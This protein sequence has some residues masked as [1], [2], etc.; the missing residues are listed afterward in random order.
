LVRAEEEPNSL[1]NE[2]LAKFGPACVLKSL[3]VMQ[4]LGHGSKLTQVAQFHTGQAVYCQR[5]L[6]QEQHTISRIGRQMR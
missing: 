4:M 6:V 2:A 1:P 5:L 3:R